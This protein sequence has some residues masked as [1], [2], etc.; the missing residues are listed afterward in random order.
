[1]RKEKGENV[2]GEGKRVGALAC[3]NVLQDRLVV[4]ALLV[5]RIPEL[6]VFECGEPGHFGL[7]F[8]L[9]EVWHVLVIRVGL[10][11]G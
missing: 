2:V 11:V 10:R 9:F 1:M 8:G 5:V 4:L 6:L 3:P 7:R